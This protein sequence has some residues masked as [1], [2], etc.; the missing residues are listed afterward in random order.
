MVAEVLEDFARDAESARAPA[1]Q[2]GGVFAVSGRKEAHP[3]EGD[4]VRSRE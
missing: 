4:S 3:R 2:A 1:E